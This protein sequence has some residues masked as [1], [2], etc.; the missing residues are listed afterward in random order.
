MSDH[1]EVM[2]A[3]EFKWYKIGFIASAKNLGH[4]IE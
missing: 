3:I 4:E 1:P 2:G